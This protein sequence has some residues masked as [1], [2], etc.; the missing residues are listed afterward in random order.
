MFICWK[1]FCFQGWYI[2]SCW[3]W[4]WC[5]N[6]RGSGYG[7]G[8]GDCEKIEFEVGYGVDLIAV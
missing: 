2:N 4:N 1:G 8:G 6:Y 5:W 3:C 7:S